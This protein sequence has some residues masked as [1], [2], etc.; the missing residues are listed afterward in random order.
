[1]DRGV[2]RFV[3]IQSL[4]I[5]VTFMLSIPIAVTAGANAAEYS[6]LLAVL[7]LLGLRVP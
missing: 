4:I 2:F 6:W 7:L 3:L 1:M 5:P